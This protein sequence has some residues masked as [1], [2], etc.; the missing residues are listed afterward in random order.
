MLALRI[1]SVSCV[2]LTACGR[3]RLSVSIVFFPTVKR[4]KALTPPP[5]LDIIGFAEKNPFS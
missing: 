3:A 5:F 2:A 1:T 4:H